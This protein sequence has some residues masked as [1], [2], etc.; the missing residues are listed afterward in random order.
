[1]TTEALA[2]T[3]AASIGN[4]SI[5]G[6]WARRG[7]RRGGIGAGPAVRDASPSRGPS[8]DG[9]DAS[10]D[11]DL[12]R[13]PL[14]VLPIAPPGRGEPASPRGA[15]VAPPLADERAP[16]QV[17]ARRRANL[18]SF[19]AVLLVHVLGLAAA[20]WIPAE[21][22]EGGGEALVL[23]VEF[24]APDATDTIDAAA[25][26]P[27]APPPIDVTADLAAATADPAP[28][29]PPPPPPN[30]ADDVA[31]VPPLLATRAARE[32]FVE[33]PPEV[34]E[35][36]APPSISPPKTSREAARPRAEAK[37]VTAPSKTKSARGAPSPAR[38]R[39][40]TATAATGS[41]DAAADRRAG[42]GLS[43]GAAAAADQGDLRSWRSAVLAALARAKVYP[44]EARSAGRSG[45]VVVRFTIRPDGSVVGLALA[46]ASGVGS[47]DAA[48]LA[49]PR[50][51]HFPPMPAGA[52]VSQSFTAGVRYDLR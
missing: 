21:E 46:S 41:G 31:T 44:E 13:L 16:A 23:A 51:A 27:Q 3:F 7:R 5:G 4:T 48:T 40:P 26:A 15:D 8:R 9:G 43:R 19:L 29:P 50:R 38:K 20:V 39:Q 25:G 52:G 45:R 24:V 28:P 35:A 2:R 18:L 42:G 22:P 6:A 11:H 32:D 33:P 17:R 10:G 49:M 30:V 36:P 34:R 14:L 1:M 47:L 37:P 12:S